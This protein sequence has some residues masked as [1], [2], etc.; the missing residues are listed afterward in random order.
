MVAEEL[1][2]GSESIADCIVAKE[3]E[4]FV[5]FWLTRRVPGGQPSRGSE[6]GDWHSVRLKSNEVANAP[7]ISMLKR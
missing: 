6:V 1:S 3:A 2:E 5:A 4:L 7:V